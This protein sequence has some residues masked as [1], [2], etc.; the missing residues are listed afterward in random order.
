MF[1]YIFNFVIGAGKL[2]LKSAAV[3]KRSRSKER[4]RRKN[5]EGCRNGLRR[6]RENYLNKRGKN[7]KAL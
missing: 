4:G 6:R 1:L 2:K 7:W 3:G 5:R